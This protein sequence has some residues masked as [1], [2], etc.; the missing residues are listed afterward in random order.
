MAA[1]HAVRAGFRLR[2]LEYLWSLE[3]DRRYNI[4]G[5]EVSTGAKGSVFAKLVVVEFNLTTLRQFHGYV[6]GICKPTDRH[7][8]LKDCFFIVPDSSTYLIFNSS[9]RRF[10]VLR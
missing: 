1:R 9:D 5:R 4:P 3:Y 8:H 7:D 6:I 2:N 10:P